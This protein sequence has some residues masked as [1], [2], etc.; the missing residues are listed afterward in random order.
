MNIIVIHEVDLY[1][2]MNANFSLDSKLK[3]ALYN[4]VLDGFPRVPLEHTDF[5]DYLYNS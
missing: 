1:Y 2:F 3:S 4:M 5:M